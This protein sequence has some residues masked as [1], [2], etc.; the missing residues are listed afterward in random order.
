MNVINCN[1]KIDDNRSVGTIDCNAF[2]YLRDEYKNDCIECPEVVS[3][4]GACPSDEIS[5]L[6]EPGEKLW[7]QIYLPEALCIPEQKPDIEQILS[8]VAYVDIISEKAIKTP[9]FTNDAGVDI[10]ITNKEGI[11][12]TG[13]KLIIEGILRQKVV[14]TAAVKEQSVHAAHFDVPFSA[15]IILEANSPIVRNYKVDAAIED[16]FIC[17]VSR[18]QIFKNVTMFLKATPLECD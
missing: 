5:N 10:A 9:V 7:T 4:K 17:K 1:C 3:I 14:Y 15:F 13:R 6:L 12:S 8:I 16:I 11:I 2:S 18:R